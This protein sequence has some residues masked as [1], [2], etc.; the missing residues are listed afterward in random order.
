M[1]EL[2]ATLGAGARTNPYPLCLDLSSSYTNHTWMTFMNN[3]ELINTPVVLSS[4]RPARLRTDR[5]L[6]PTCPS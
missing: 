4:A 5:M 3:G 1:R 2:K 6:L